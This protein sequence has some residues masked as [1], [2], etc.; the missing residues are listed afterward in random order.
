MSKY[1]ISVETLAEILE[2]ADL[3]DGEA[4]PRADYSGRGMYGDT[5]FGITFSSSTGLSRFMVAAG[6]ATAN[7][8]AD[9]DV[10]PDDVLDSLALAN[11][12]CTDS[13]GRDMIAYW[14]GWTLEGDLADYFDEE[15]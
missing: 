6:M 9:D 12:T 2:S 7:Q 1:T 5:C 13:M 4:R 15:V 14:P 11:A 10:R 3:F 8:E